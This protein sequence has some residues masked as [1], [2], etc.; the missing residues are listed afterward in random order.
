MISLDHL[1]HTLIFLILKFFP[2]KMSVPTKS[3]SGAYV[4]DVAKSLTIGS[5]GVTPYVWAT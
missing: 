4:L 3:L 5:D 2:R 1:A